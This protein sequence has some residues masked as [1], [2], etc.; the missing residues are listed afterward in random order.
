MTPPPHEFPRMLTAR[1]EGWLRWVLPVERQGYRDAWESI[2]AKAVIG[3]G[4]RG[5]GEIILGGRGEVPDFSA[6]LAAVFAYGFIETDTG[7][8][9]V[10][11]REALEGQISVEIV[12]HRVADLPDEFQELRRW[13]YSTWS[14]GK[15]CQQCEKKVREVR[16]QSDT[17][18]E[19]TLALCPNDRRLWIFDA[20]HQVNRPI[21]VTNF[22]NELMLHKNIR[23]PNIALNAGRLFDDLRAY[24]DA[25]LAG[26]F[27]SYNRLR[28][29]VENS[30]NITV[31]PPADG[32][33]P[34]SF[35][36][37]LFSSR[38]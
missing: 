13:T 24:S 21:P 4:R 34:S 8:I 38:R 18:R 31:V 32:A 7:G 29:K 36:K 10:T 22:Y 37:K 20:A 28:A 3:Q 15:P 12:G 25:D 33:T 9:S 6:P 35:L 19:F 5:K 1:E 2:C 17:G 23:D 26:A 27:R 30:G 14:P 16:M 11:V